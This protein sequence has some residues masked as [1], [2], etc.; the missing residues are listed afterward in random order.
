MAVDGALGDVVAVAVGARDE[1]RPRIDALRRAEERCEQQ[2]L[3]G[4]QL[5]LGVAPRAAMPL[6]VELERAVADDEALRDVG[7]RA[8]AV[9]CAARAFTRATSSRGLN[10]F[11]T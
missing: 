3:R 8:R 1:V 5:D 11:V 4:G 2:E 7:E 10:G 9:R 6:D